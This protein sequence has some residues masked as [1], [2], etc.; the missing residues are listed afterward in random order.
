[1]IDLINVCLFFYQ[2]ILSKIEDMIKN[3]QLFI[4][5]LNN[6]LTFKVYH[7]YECFNFID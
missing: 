3:K 5:S 1:M 7:D 2:M 6:L 4:S